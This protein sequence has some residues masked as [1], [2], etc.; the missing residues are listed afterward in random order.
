MKISYAITVKSELD[1]IQRLIPFLLEHKRDED[2]IVVLWDDSGDIK[3]WEYLHDHV[4][5]FKFPGFKINK[6]KFQNHFADWKNQL[7]SLCS[8]D[9]I[10]QID[11]DEILNQLFINNL[12]NI[13]ESNPS[14]DVYL[15]PREN[16][17]N[18]LTDN[19]IKKWGWKVD[20]K[21]RI[22]YPDYQWRIYRNDSLIKWVNKVHEKLEGY[23]Q[24]STLPQDS[25]FDLNHTK[26]IERQESQ[27]N[28][29]DTL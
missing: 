20:D 2:E 4:D 12:N 15:V 8:G 29:Y 7:T 23:R 22:N 25:I 11:A 17:V 18:G 3:V 28:Y 21:N 14:I 6:G 16:Y 9:F 1:E 26:S 5:Y 19:H 13:I 24:F 27:N 10:F